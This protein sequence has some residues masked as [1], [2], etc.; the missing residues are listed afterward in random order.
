[1]EKLIKTKSPHEIKTIC[2][3]ALQDIK[4]Q[5]I[6]ALHVAEFT[7]ITDYMIIATGSSTAHVKSIFDRVK[8]ALKA[9][10]IE[11][12]GVEGLD[13]AQWVLCDA[14]DVVIHIMLPESRQYYSLEKIWSVEKCSYA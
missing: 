13:T 7:S 8:K 1:M 12:L 14:A 5:D 9:N 10:Q 6:I 3:D 11:I 4:A 2:V